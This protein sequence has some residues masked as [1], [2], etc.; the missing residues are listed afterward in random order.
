MRPFH[1]NPRLCLLPLP[2]RLLYSHSQPAAR[3]RFASTLSSSLPALLLLLFFRLLLG[4]LLLLWCVSV[5]VF[6]L[7]VCGDRRKA[8]MR[9]RSQC[10]QPIYHAIQCNRPP[11]AFSPTFFS[12]FFTFFFSFLRRFRSR[13]LSL[14]SD[15]EELLLLL[16]LSLPSSSRR[17]SVEG[18]RSDAI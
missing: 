9:A 14:E 18:G 12:R 3:P 13:S 17:R 11:P 4:P 6:V 16:S 10:P 2:P 5:R 15:D 1:A 8:V 7:V